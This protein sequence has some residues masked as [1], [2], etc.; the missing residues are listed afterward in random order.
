[1]A[2]LDLPYEGDWHP[3]IGLHGDV[4]VEEENKPVLHM[5]ELHENHCEQRWTKPRPKMVS[6]GSYKY[7]CPDG[8]LLFYDGT[9]THH[10]SQDL[11]H[12]TSYDGRCLAVLP[13]G[14]RA[15]VKKTD[16]N[17]SNMTILPDT[18][19]LFVTSVHLSHCVSHSQVCYCG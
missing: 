3:A 5:Y 9:R 4:I 7:I 19:L 17:R 1:M 6:K 16:A 2:A 11:N 18:F 12:I 10:F 13:S 14:R 8:T 15:I